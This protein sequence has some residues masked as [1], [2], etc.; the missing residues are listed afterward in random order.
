[1]TRT[2]R[3]SIAV[4]LAALAALPSA[5]QYAKDQKSAPPKKPPTAEQ[6]AEAKYYE[7]LDDADLQPLKAGKGFLV[8]PPPE[9]VEWIGGEALTAES[10][11]GKVTVIQSVGGKGNARATLERVKKALPEGAVLV[12]LHTPE[13][14]DRADDTL[15]KNPPCLIAVDRAGEWCDRLGVWKRPVNVVVGPNAT[16]ELV[17]LS[18][19]GLKEKVKPLLAVEHDP[20]AQP[21]ERPSAVGNVSREAAPWPEFL[22]P[23]NEGSAKDMRGKKV[24]EFQVAQWLSPAPDPGK[25]LI[26]VDFWATWCGPC[27]ASIP[28]LN[29]L[30]KRYGKD[31]LVVGISNEEESKF[32]EGLKKAKLR[33]DTFTYSVALDPKGT[34]KDGFF[35]VRGIPHMAIWSADGIVRWQGHPMTLQ[36][37]DIERLVAA[38]RANFPAADPKSARSWAESLPKGQKSR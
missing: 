21:K 7:K 1:M 6:K 13:G 19:L 28:H 20:E 2:S 23:I 14:A 17:G 26:A 35:G 15:G 12:A 31:I 37:A 33:P 32:T 30:N 22:S 8:P 10:F 34:L 5:A 25:R 24:P 18:E 9:S 38:N 11:V 27:V 16:V 3:T 29:D 4:L 36:D